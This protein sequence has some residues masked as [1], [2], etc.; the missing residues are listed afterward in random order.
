MRRATQSIFK[1]FLKGASTSR[2]PR[3]AVCQWPAVFGCD[4][5]QCA[6]QQD[7]IILL[8]TI[9]PFF[10]NAAEK[11]SAAFIDY[12]SVDRS[13]PIAVRQISTCSMRR[14]SISWIVKIRSSYSITVSSL[15]SGMWPKRSSKNPA[16]VS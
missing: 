1:L 2:V 3:L 10:V 16:T 13:S 6:I 7:L 4:A 14:S 8:H 15:S 12:S 11:Y 5:L 9:S